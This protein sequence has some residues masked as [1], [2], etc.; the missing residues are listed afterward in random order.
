MRTS[1]KILAALVLL[2]SSI[3]TRVEAQTVPAATITALVETLKDSDADVRKQAAWAL[4]RIRSEQ[5]VDGLI[6][7]MR[8]SDQEVRKQAIWALGRLESP[9][10]VDAL[11]AALKDS[12]TEVQIGRASC[13]E[14]V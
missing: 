3:G 11:T 13:R 12:N 6:A 8:D 7:A 14:S 4:G 1:A 2:A 5:A 9:K 10:A